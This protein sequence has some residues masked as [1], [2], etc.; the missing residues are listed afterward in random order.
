[1][2]RFL[3]FSSDN[4]TSCSNTLCLRG[5]H[6]PHIF[7]IPIM[8]GCDA[9]DMTTHTGQNNHLSFAVLYVRTYVHIVRVL[10]GM[11]VLWV[12]IP[13]EVVYFSLKSDCFRRIVLPC[14]VLIAWPCLALLERAVMLISKTLMNSE[15]QKNNNYYW[16]VNLCSLIIRWNTDCFLE[17]EV[18]EYMN[19]S[20]IICKIPMLHM[21]FTFKYQWNI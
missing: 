20:W 18:T 8:T 9:T 6:V 3:C 21:F 2:E 11:W 19:R 15:K 1:M 4:D 16:H 12:Q 5:I 10:L 13:P 17:K 7:V 14:I